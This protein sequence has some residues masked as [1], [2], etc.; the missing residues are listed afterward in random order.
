[1]ESRETII[2]LITSAGSAFIGWIVG[3]RKENADI[4]TI[5][6]ENSQKVIDMFTAMNEKLKVDQLSQKVDDLTIEIE[7]LRV[8]NHNLKIGK[9]PKV[10]KT[11]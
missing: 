10:V 7:S 6:L 8:E 11:K 2:A 9:A 5:Q 4:S 3:K 1:M